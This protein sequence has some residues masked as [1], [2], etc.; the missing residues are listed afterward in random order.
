MTPGSHKL[1]A[2]GAQR[3]GNDLVAEAVE[4]G[5]R[6]AAGVGLLWPFDETVTRRPSAT[7]LRREIA[8]TMD[9]EDA[10]MQALW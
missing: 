10:G 5:Q 2:G 1:P 7:R 3:P 4:V 8:S 6:L 9:R